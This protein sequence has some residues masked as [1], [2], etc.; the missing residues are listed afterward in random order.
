MSYG[1]ETNIRGGDN[2]PYSLTDFKAI[3]PQFDTIVSDTILTNFI[4]LANASLQKSRWHDIWEI[5]MAWFVAHFATLYIESI[6]NTTGG[7]SAV[8]NAASAK[9][10]LT[11][12]SVDSVSASYDYG[13]I[14]EDLNG[15]AAW[16]STKYGQ[17]LATFGSMF[18]KGGMYI[19]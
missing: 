12:K 8:I 15:W 3:F 18:G 9:G 2:P 19:C 13:S 7:P 14:S 10:L 4:G 6:A 17:Q 1:A 11:S 16:K 5:A